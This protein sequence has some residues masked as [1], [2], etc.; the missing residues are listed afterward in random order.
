MLIVAGVN[1]W[2]SAIRDVVMQLHP[3]TTGAIE[4][5]LSAAPPKVEPPL[6]LRVER[7]PDVLDDHAAFAAE[8]ESLLRE[9]L[10]VSAKVELV[11]PGV[12][13]RAE[14]KSQFIRRVDG[15]RLVDQ[16]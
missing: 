13:P 2:P 15:P 10:I 5:L 16:P 12:L 3:R 1:V 6:R 14:M 4:I 9:R 8:V 7:G 11:D